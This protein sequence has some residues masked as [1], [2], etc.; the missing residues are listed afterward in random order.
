MIPIE[1]DRVKYTVLFV[2]EFEGLGALEE[3]AFSQ[4]LQPLIFHR[5][6]ASALCVL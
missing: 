5:H 2:P 6:I 3:P 1:C 4:H